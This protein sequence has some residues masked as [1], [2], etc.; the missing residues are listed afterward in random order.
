MG[1]LNIDF[2]AR[3]SRTKTRNLYSDVHLD[4]VN[5]YKIR[6]NY[7]KN[8]TRL[9]DIK[10]A[11]DMEAI[12]NSMTSLFSTYPGQ[13]L[14]L[15]EYGLNIKRFLFSPVSENTAISIG[16]LIF[17]AIEKW[18]SR[19]EVRD[20]SIMPR[21]EAAQYD[22]FLDFYVPS[23]KKS[24]NFLGSILQGDGFIRG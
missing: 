5:D 9:I 2:L 23:L 8:E 19:V 20:L 7:H 3:D 4:I 1:S 14:L 17:E 12:A 18:E 13:R 22:I 16:E 15:P 6:G 24:A 11:Y 21:I 10:V